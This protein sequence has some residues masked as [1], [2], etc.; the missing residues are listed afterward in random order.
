[1]P[2]TNLQHAGKLADRVRMAVENL[3]VSAD[4][5]TIK[6]T[7]SI[8]VSTWDE[9]IKNIDAMIEKSDAALYKAKNTGRNRVVAV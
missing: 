4:G 7:V 3:I 5:A 2:E 6:L 1:M 8:G 9:G